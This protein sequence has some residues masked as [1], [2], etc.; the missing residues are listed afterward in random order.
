MTVSCKRAT[1]RVCWLGLTF[2]PA[3]R[4]FR[5]IVLRVPRDYFIT[6]L[7][8]WT[9]L[10]NQ[11]SVNWTAGY[12]IASM[13]HGRLWTEGVD[14]PLRKRRLEEESLWTFQ[15]VDKLLL[16]SIKDHSYGALC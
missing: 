13:V 1:R 6:G 2:R 9:R 7:T 15:R 12:E 16:G 4:R 5:D 3:A 14:R 8:N 10:E 11:A